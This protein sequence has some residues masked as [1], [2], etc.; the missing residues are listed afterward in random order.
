MRDLA[1][2]LDL[3]RGISPAAAGTD[4]TALVS[5]ILDTKGLA[6][7]VFAILAGANTDTDV[8]FTVL[9]E[10]GDDS[11][12]SDHTAVDDAFL[13]GTEIKAGFQFDDDNEMRKIGYVGGKRY[14]RV[15]ITPVGNNSGNIFIAGA[16]ITQPYDLPTAN[17]PA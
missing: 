17:P 3:K 7:A 9:V 14:V 12:L 13:T 4:N 8:T 11:G 1:N 2:H 15:T 6:G 10:D 5:Q 16:W